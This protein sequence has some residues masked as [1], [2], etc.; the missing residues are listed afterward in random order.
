[1]KFKLDTSIYH[2]L[3]YKNKWLYVT[4]GENIFITC[5]K[6]KQSVNHKLSGVGVI[7]LNEACK[8]FTERDILIPGEIN[9]LEEY[10]DFIPTSKILHLEEHL[11]SPIDKTMFQDKYIKSN[12]LYNLNEVAKPVSYFQIKKEMD[13]N[14]NKY[15][16][17]QRN[18]GYLLYAVTG[19]IFISISIFW[20]K[21]VNEILTRRN[22]NRIQNREESI[23]LQ[24]TAPVIE[25]P[26]IIPIRETTDENNLA[27]YP[28]LRT[29]F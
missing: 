8:G 18:N 2:K 6:E 20:I 22:T 29:E 26:E 27:L 12:Q 13:K 23:Q 16:D 21:K 17:I 10:T 24:A 28:K 11:T 7:S 9:H 5:N 3:T 19:I 15:I 14:Q 4:K 25:P 1:M